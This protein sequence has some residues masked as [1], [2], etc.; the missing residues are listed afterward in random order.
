MQ[1][2]APQQQLPVTAQPPKSRVR[3]CP[4][5]V[6][7]TSCYAEYM[8]KR[9]LS[10]GF[11]LIELMVTITIGAILLGL[12]VPMMRNIVERNAVSGQVNG[13]VGAVNLARSEA[14]KRGIP[15]VMCRSTNAEISATPTCVASGVGWESGWI[16][17]AD[18][19]GSTTTRQMNWGSSDSD[20]LLRVQGAITDTGG[21]EQNSFDK[22]IFRP[23]GLMSSGASQFTF[24][25]RSLTSDQQ[26]RVCILMSGRTRLINNSIDICD[27]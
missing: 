13:F 7:C 15:V 17:F 3:R 19:S 21:I 20:V 4:I 16:V 9:S 10:R 12:G 18:R 2:D 14:I 26:R 22:L 5:G 6:I 8:S 27:S 23:T 11:T 24:N 25:S 1:A